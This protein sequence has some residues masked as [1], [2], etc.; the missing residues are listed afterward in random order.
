MCHLLAGL[1]NGFL[2]KNGKTII[3]IRRRSK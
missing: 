1:L 2:K 3:V